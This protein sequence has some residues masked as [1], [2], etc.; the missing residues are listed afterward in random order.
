[1]FVPVNSEQLQGRGR[2]DEEGIDELDEAG[3][4]R[5]VEELVYA[6]IVMI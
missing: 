1:M 4:G 6:W 3:Y 5:L 2:L